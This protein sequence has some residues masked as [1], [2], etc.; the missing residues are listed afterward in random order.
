MLTLKGYGGAN[1][2]GSE[3]IVGLNTAGGSINLEGVKD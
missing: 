3:Q 2:N 1:G